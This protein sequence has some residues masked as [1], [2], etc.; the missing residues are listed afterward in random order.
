[1]NSCALLNVPH[2][3]LLLIGL[4]ATLF[5]PM[6]VHSELLLVVG[7][8]DNSGSPPW[9]RGLD[10]VVVVQAALFVYTRLTCLHARP[11]VWQ[12]MIMVVIVITIR[13][14]FRATLMNGFATTAYIYESINALPRFAF[15]TLVALVALAAGRSSHH[16]WRR[17]G[18]G[19]A[20]S[21]VAYGLMHTCLDP[22]LHDLTTRYADL[23][24]DAVVSLPYPAWF[25]A[26]S[27]VTFIEPVIVAVLLARMFR[28]GDRPLGIAPMALVIMAL[29]SNITRTFVDAF[30][31]AIPASQYML[32]GSQFLFEG[33]LLGGLAAWTW[34]LA[35]GMPSAAHL[36]QRKDS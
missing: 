34:C 23:A 32:Q 22:A 26:L 3:W 10:F 5:V 20:A 29:R 15:A 25:E 30:F 27:Y 8:P 31:Q 1:V 7:Y 14:G 17:A 9:V 11:V 33:L 12:A 19:V 35:D 2:P 16:A 36:A 6:F 28:N 21:L 4:A 18:V 13:E 24:H